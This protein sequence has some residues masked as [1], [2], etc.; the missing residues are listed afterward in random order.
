MNS[1]RFEYSLL[2]SDKHQLYGACAGESHID[3]RE[4]AS[5]HPSRCDSLSRH[6]SK[7]EMN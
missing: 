1:C 6:G 7:V 5:W 4:P 2:A 3:E